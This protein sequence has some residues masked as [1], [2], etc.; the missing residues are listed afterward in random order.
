MSRWLPL[1]FV[2]LF[3]VQCRPGNQPTSSNARGANRTDGADAKV[4]GPDCMDE[5][6]PAYQDYEDEET[7]AIEPTSVAGG[8]L[9]CLKAADPAFLACQVQNEKT[10]V[11]VPS[12]ARLDWSVASGGNSLP[13]T[14]KVHDALAA[15][16]YFYVNM[17]VG[18]VAS[19]SLSVK[20]GEASDTLSFAMTSLP[21]DD[22]TITL[23]AMPAVEIPPSSI[24]STG[25]FELE[26]TLGNGVLSDENDGCLGQT[27]GNTA[28]QTVTKDI[29]Y[30][31]DAGKVS[32][33]ADGICGLQKNNV[34]MALTAQPPAKQVLVKLVPNAKRLLMFKNLDFV[35]GP[36][37]FTFG[38]QG[39]DTQDDVRLGSFTFVH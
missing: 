4:Q 20:E 17:P 19:V 29:N 14:A 15:G 38:Y 28:S 21:P 3:I 36:M 35:P 31:D 22:T 25:S 8:F 1:L 13:T 34:Y 33:Y 39:N 9:T 32:L 23:A 24:D 37:S 5:G 10:Q 6:C 26:Q 27:D 2:S 7:V 30:A 16:T 18:D 11:R 12:S